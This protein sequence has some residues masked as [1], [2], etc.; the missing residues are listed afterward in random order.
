[1]AAT[2]LRIIANVLTPPTQSGLR[3][4][5]A[6]A[7]HGEAQCAEGVKKL[8]DAFRPTLI[9]VEMDRGDFC[10]V[11]SSHVPGRAPTSAYQAAAA[12]AFAQ[13]VPECDAAFRWAA[14]RGAFSQQVG[15]E[16]PVSIVPIDRSQKTTRRR[17][18]Q[19]LAQQPGQLFRARRYFGRVPQ[20]ADAGGVTAWR[21]GLQRDCPL[22]HEVLF[23][24]RDEYMSY[25]ILLQLELQIAR[26]NHMVPERAAALSSLSSLSEREQEAELTL[27][28]ETDDLGLDIDELLQRCADRTGARLNAA[29]EWSLDGPELGSG[30]LADRADWP[31]V[32]V[33]AEEPSVFVLCGPAHVDGLTARLQ[34][35]LGGGADGLDGGLAARRFLAQN[36]AVLPRSLQDADGA[37]RRGAASSSSAEVQSRHEML[38]ATVSS[39]LTRDADAACEDAGSKAATGQPSGATSPGLPGSGDG[40]GP[41]ASLAAYVWRQLAGDSGANPQVAKVH[42]GSVSRVALGTVFIHDRVRDLSIQPLPIWPVFVI[43]YV[44]VP[45]ALFVAIPAKIDTWWMMQRLSKTDE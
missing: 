3:I 8:L 16:P 38:T 24:E 6:G 31:D 37:S 7:P 45:F 15:S 18:A 23:E 35:V 9:C 34:S 43:A 44:M 32:K 11:G 27:A 1:M 39:A 36:S 5:I 22:L 17:L 10:S 30:G 2:G 41:L 20:V 12:T 21:D 4:L 25:Q 29:M 33:G 13:A 42:G 19:R 40:L 28:R 26:G 14:A